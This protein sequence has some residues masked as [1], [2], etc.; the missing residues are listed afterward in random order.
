[1]SIIQTIRE[2]AAWLVFGLIALSLAG[3]ILMDARSRL[4]GGGGQS[5]T[6]G[7]V[8]GQNIELADFQKKVNDVE[9]Q[10]KANN[11]AVPES[12]QEEIRNQI[13]QQMVQ[14]IVL[15]DDYTGLGL[16]V[17]DRELSDMLAG[18][19]PIQQIR[20]AFTDPNTGV[21]DPQQAAARINQFRS[22]YK[23]GPRKGQD[24]REYEV[25]K[26]FIEVFIP[27]SIKMR[28]QEKY[29][30]L[31]ANSAYVP[32][33][34]IEKTNV[35]N[36]EMASI[37][38]IN[39]PY[40]TIPDSTV[41]VTDDE[42]QQYIDKHKDQYQQPDSRSIAYVAFDVV[43]TSDDSSRLYQ[44]MVE[45]KKDFTAADNPVN[46]FAR[47][48]SDIN[49]EDAYH[50]KSEIRVPF[51]DSIF[52]LQKGGTFGPYQDAGSYVVAKMIDEK[53]LPDSSH[54]RHI[55]VATTDRNGR[56]LMEDSVAKKKIDSIRNLI[57]KGA[58]FDSVAA[59][60]SDDP[61]SK[62]KGGDYGWIHQGQMVK[63]F[64]DFIFNGKKGD[65]KIVKT[66]FGYH[67]VEILDQKNFEPAYKVAYL[68][69][70]I[71]ASTATDQAANGMASQF[72]GQSRDEKSFDDNVQKQHLNKLLATE[73][74]TYA[75]NIP[76]L[77]YSRS[78]VQWIYKSDVGTVS[79]PFP[80]GEKYVVAVVTAINKEGT[81]SPARAR[82]LVEPV[83]RNQKKGEIISKKLGTPASL[84]AAASSNNQTVQ[85]ADS[86]YFSSPSIN[87]INEGK[88]VGAAFDKQLAGKPASAPI[89]DRVGVFVIKVEN[90]GARSNPEA[91][92]RQQRF[93][94]EQQEKNQL[95]RGFMESFSRR[96]T[97]KDYR[98]KF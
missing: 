36:S 21:F 34:M 76:G 90:V 27:N 87:G 37:S 57:D 50:P 30:S 9:E 98:G 93:M 23:T 91:D 5:T 26:N 74:P 10:Y 55:L 78:L 73:V 44:Q 96:A 13:W 40:T 3:F 4:F 51:K 82:N 6:M 18:Q 42:I 48:S 2:R 16:D 24:N 85:K 11:M 67:Y 61:G 92:I 8:N 38:Y 59:K 64:N 65:K 39:I 22:L 19:N 62:D 69:R 81:Q 68:S 84:E 43:P 35:D 12:Q 32:K 25:A 71:E 70:K 52:A 83:L 46:F 56:T 89:A 60:L 20:Q 88:V 97:I 80:V 58:R 72:A 95:F 77:G 75:Y 7:S 45:L 33:W 28:L 1:M 17:S 94:Q 63:E 31:L 49:Y 29:V 15:E 79:D 53:T 47:V 86:I 41:K 14:S 54:A 66:Q